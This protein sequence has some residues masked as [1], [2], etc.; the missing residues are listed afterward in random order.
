[1]ANKN[2]IQKPIKT[3]DFLHSTNDLRYKEKSKL[4]IAIIVTMTISIVFCLLTLI[5]L[6]VTR[7]TGLLLPEHLLGDIFERDDGNAERVTLRGEEI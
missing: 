2:N 3:A 6:A 7:R 4:N 1:M 5:Y